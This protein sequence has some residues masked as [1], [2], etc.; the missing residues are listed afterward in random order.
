MKTNR[1]NNHRIRKKSF[2][3]FYNKHFADNLAPVEFDTE[4]KEFLA[5][6]RTDERRIINLLETVQLKEAFKNILALGKR[7][8][9]FFHEQEP[10][11]T[12]KTKPSTAKSTVVAL[13]PRSLAR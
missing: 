12:I 2:E 3:V 1:T 5:Q 11:A 13:I 9:K 7:G 10:W 6:I 4:Q 8:N